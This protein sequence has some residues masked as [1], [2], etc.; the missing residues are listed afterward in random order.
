MSIRTIRARTTGMTA[1]RAG[2]DRRR[3][4]GTSTSASTEVTGASFRSFSQSASTRL[5]GSILMSF[6][7]AELSR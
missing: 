6:T 1:S 3:A 7:I 4:R 2:A 5:S